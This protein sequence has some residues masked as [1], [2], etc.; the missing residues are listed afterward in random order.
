MLTLWDG[1]STVGQ[2]DW[3][4]AGMVV[5]TS[6]A[7]RDAVLETP[8]KQKKAAEEERVAKRVSDSI[9]LKTATQRVETLAKRLAADSRS[10]WITLPENNAVAVL[11]IRDG[12]FVAIRSFGYKDYSVEGNGLDPTDNDGPPP[13]IQTWPIRG[14]YMP[15]QVAIAV[16]ID[17]P[18][19]VY[20]DRGVR[21]N[22][23]V[24]GD[25]VRLSSMPKV[26]KPPLFRDLDPAVFPPGDPAT[27]ALR[28]LQLKVSWVDGDSN[29]S[30]SLQYLPCRL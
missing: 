18:V 27:L 14:I 19:L 4:L 24:F 10:A 9:I 8:H 16:P 12:K 28:H 20:P 26:E 6:C 2:E 5:D 1:R 22:L 25:E 13:N 23:A 7:V 11:D 29:G 17:F 21:R 15:K 30:K 3:H